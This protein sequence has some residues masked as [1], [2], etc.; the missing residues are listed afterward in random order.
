[1]TMIDIFASINVP[2]LVAAV[3]I[4]VFFADAVRSLRKWIF[5]KFSKS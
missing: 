3:I 5:G 2:T 1:M 4:S